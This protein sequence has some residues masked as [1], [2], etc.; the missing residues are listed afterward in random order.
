M[1]TSLDLTG[2]P[3]QAEQEI[4][5]LIGNIEKPFLTVEELWEK[6]DQAWDEQ[7]CNNIKLDWERIALFYNHPVWLLNGLFSEQDTISLNYRYA[8]LDW[9]S[10]NRQNITSVV[11]YGGGFGTVARII[12]EKEKDLL[13]HIYEPYP[14][15]FAL[16]RLKKY[17]NIRFVNILTNSYNCLISLDVLEH[18]PDPLKILGEMI[19]SVNVGGYLIIAN[20][21]H[22]VIQ[23]H[24]PCTF[25]LRYTFNYF[26]RLMGLQFLGSCQGSHAFVYRKVSDHPVNWLLVRQAEKISKIAFPLLSRVHPRYQKLKAKFY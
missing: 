26:A 18:V 3:E 1:S 15:A 23:C 12:A 16:E 4:R 19:N 14:H 6:I 22:P 7:G 10:A 17:Q 20:H 25:H 8:I 5:R 21:F 2:L 13:I 9:I 24:L 11:D